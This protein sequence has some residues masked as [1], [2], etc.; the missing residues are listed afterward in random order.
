M[1]VAAVAL[2]VTACARPPA[3]APTPSA[4]A[5]PAPARNVPPLDDPA[6]RARFD[7]AVE[8]QR[9]QGFDPGASI[10]RGSLIGLFAGGFVGGGLGALFGLINDVP[11]SSAAAGAIVGGGAGATVGG[12][13]ALHLDGAAYVRGLD[14]CLA[15]HTAGTRT[16]AP[17]IA[18]AGLVEYRLRMVSLRHE[19]F[20]SY[21]STTELTNGASGPGLMRLAAAADAGA[22]ERGIV[23]YDRHLVPAPESVARAFGATPVDARVRLG[24][25]GRDVWDE[26]RWL[27]RPG[28]RTVWLVTPRARRAQELR[29]IGLSDVSAL[30]QFRPA[31][32][33]MLGGAAEAVV[34]VP[35]PYLRHV[36]ERGEAGAYVDRALDRSRGIGALVAVNHDAAF[37]D[38]V[39]L[40]ITHA[41]NTATYEAVLAWGPRGEGREL[42]R[43]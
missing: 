17:P 34:T 28:E 9:A 11:G 4:L 19:A 13:L 42:P 1:V 29:R 6:D 2:L 41:V 27:G 36:E 5:P 22:L 15:A 32:A 3:L 33:G 25:G 16:S 43:E 40:V 24:G 30:A 37:P 8:V 12:P 35:L 31:S 18:E 26:A 20:A 39:Y 21:L 14:A 10:T 38:L 23:L 7:C